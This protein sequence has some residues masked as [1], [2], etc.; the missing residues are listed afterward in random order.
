MKYNLT[1]ATAIVVAN[2]IGTGVFTSLGFQLFDLNNIS[3]IAALWILGGVIAVLGS[4]CYAEL[5]STFPRSGG[6]YHFLRLSFGKPVGF[7]SGWTSAI[8]GFAAPIAAS[9]YAFSKYFLNVVPLNLPAEVIAIILVILVTVIH[10]LKMHIGAKVQVFFTIGKILLLILFILAGFFHISNGLSADVSTQMTTDLNQTDF[11]KSGFWI[12][13]IFVSYAYSG[14]NASAYIIDEIDNPVK[15]VPRSIF[16][17]TFLVTSLYVLINVVFML[18]APVN[19]L[20]GKEDVAHVA[21]KFIFGPVGAS[22]VSGMVSFFLVSTIGSMIIVGPRVMKRMASD[23]KE[24]NYFAKENQNNVPVRAILLQSGIA[25]ILLLTSSFENIITT[26]GFILSIFTTLTAI[27]LIILRIKQ[28]NEPRPLKAPFYPVMPVLFVVFNLWTIGYLVKEKNEIVIAGFIFLLV[29][30]VIYLFLNKSNKF[31]SKAGLII[32]FMLSLFS[33]KNNPQAAKNES[34]TAIKDSLQTQIK[35][36]IPFQ[37]DA[38]LDKRAAE[39]SGMD[40]VSFTNENTI[41][42]IKRLSK[43]WERKDKKIITP[44]REWAAAEKISNSGATNKRL[45]FYPFS[46]PDFEFANAFYSEADTYVMC[47]LENAGNDS[48]LMFDKKAPVDEF[49]QSAERYF[50]FSDQLGFFR[51]IDMA[52]HFKKR[53]VVDIIALYIKRAGGKIG[54]ASLHHWNPS[55]G[56]LTAPTDRQKKANVCSFNFQY[57]SGKV[58]NIYYFEKDLSDKALEQDSLWLSW[59][60]KEAG[61]KKIVSLTKS[62]S[63]LLQ[64]GGFEKVKSFILNHADIHI[65]DDSGISYRSLSESGKKLQLYGSYSSVIPLFRYYFQRDMADRY[66]SENAN[67]GKLPFFIGYN[68]E[69]GETSLQVLRRH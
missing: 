4:F 54:E 3:S 15:N 69:H 22:I 45:V 16:I 51:T 32:I 62:A 13:L 8:V 14:W 55:T 56:E 2:M 61:N 67:I 47:G 58:S 34:S 6:E 35:S 66:K 46:G 41:R 42:Y 28:P 20:K 44:I 5:S 64:S 30:L 38:Y 18:A 53:G 21:A 63:Y 60:K 10:S 36:E 57:P 43:N 17:G 49:I 9:A 11:M 33:C 23:Y 37:V 24:F 52:R 1:T 12:S 39:L 50:Y 68:L 29:G 65:Q 31:N 26:I 40:S 48:S 19:E 27:G 25:I 59:V 7:L